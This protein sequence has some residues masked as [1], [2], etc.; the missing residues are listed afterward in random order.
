MV[1][2]IGSG[3]Y[4]FV[5]SVTTTQCGV[6]LLGKLENKSREIDAPGKPSITVCLAVTASSFLVHVVDGFH[7]FPGY[8]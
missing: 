3:G 8:S 5:N 6:C 1:D 4:F 7:A 2:Q